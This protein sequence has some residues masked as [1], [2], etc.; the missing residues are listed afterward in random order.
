VDF[1]IRQALKGKKPREA[2]FDELEIN[3]RFGTSAVQTV[4]AL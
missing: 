1:Q 2:A 4:R 3:D